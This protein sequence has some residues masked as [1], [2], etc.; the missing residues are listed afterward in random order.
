MKKLIFCVILFSSL[1]GNVEKKTYNFGSDPIDVIIPCTGKDKRTLELCIEGIKKHGKNIRRVIV[2][3]SKRLT[4]KAQ[5]F[6]ENLYPFSKSDIAYALFDSK[7]EA[8]EYINNPSNRL[9]WL[10]Q[11]LLKF[12]VFDVIP[13]ISANVLLL[14]ADTIF[15]KPVSFISEGGGGLLNTGTENWEPYFIHAKKFLPG[16]KKLYKG[17]SGISHHMLI[18]K[19]IISDLF[20][21]VETYHKNP[22]WKAFCK[23]IRKEDIYF[24]GA[25]E[26]EIYFNFALAKTDQIKIRQLHWDN[27]FEL[28]KV[29]KFRKKGYN[30]VSCHFYAQ[31]KR[32]FSFFTLWEKAKKKVFCLSKN[33]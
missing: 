31:K 33:K 7:K 18:Q 2:I 24:S 27:I 16:F 23:C 12:Y 4:K 5:W 10:Y 30:Y 14:D 20:K 13:G 25:S 29:K 32:K 21:I 28:R 15:L 19:E 22:L 11:Q 6:D 17:F 3:S 26:Y 9:G 8:E 1:F